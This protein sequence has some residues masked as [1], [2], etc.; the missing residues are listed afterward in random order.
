MSKLSITKAKQVFSEYLKEAGYKE[1]TITG[2]MQYLKIFL[3]Y[4][5]LHLKK[6]DLRE[7]GKSEIKSFFAYAQELVSERTTKVYAKRSKTALYG[8]VKLFFRC[9]YLK[10]LILIN[11]C[12]DY[13]WKAKGSEGQR[14]VLSEEE[15]ASF[16]DQVDIDAYLGLR[17]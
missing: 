8:T 7:L 16:L 10:E 14:V 4:V 3:H 13:E 11:P 15:M 12:Q 5:S 6:D 17:D 1:H 9:L 2:K